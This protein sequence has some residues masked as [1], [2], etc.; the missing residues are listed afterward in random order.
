MVL[1]GPSWLNLELSGLAKKFQLNILMRVPPPK[2]GL[3]WLPRFVPGDKI[4]GQGLTILGNVGGEHFW[5]QALFRMTRK[6]AV[7][8][9]LVRGTTADS[10][11]LLASRNVQKEAQPIGMQNWPLSFSLVNT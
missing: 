4:W 10:E 2:K 1:P 11:F 5:R 8:C 9:C 7:K 3:F 6:G